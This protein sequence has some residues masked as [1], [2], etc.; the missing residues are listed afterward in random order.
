MSILF[1]LYTLFYSILLAYILQ[2]KLLGCH[3]SPFSRLLEMY[4]LKEH[5]WKIYLFCLL[6]EIRWH[7]SYHFAPRSHGS[8]SAIYAWPPSLALKSDKWALPL[9]FGCGESDGATLIC[10]SSISFN[11]LSCAELM[12][13]QESMTEMFWEVSVCKTL[14]SQALFYCFMFTFSHM[15]AVLSYCWWKPKMS[16]FCFTITAFE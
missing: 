5:F 10:I 7:D 11:G 6:S 4:S 14:S 9:S 15:E 1:V 8:Y 16:R 3:P 2:M 13:V 12:S